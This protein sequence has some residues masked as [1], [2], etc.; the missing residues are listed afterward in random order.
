MYM[1]HVKPTWLWASID[2][3]LLGHLVHQESQTL[4][5]LYTTRQQISDAAIDH[6]LGVLA[7]VLW[8]QNNF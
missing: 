8:I 2:S 3:P 7:A 1:V 6:D 4:A 5:P